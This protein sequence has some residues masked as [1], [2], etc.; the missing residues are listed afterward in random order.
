MIW[1]GKFDIDCYLELFFL[2]EY[3]YRP[4]PPLFNVFGNTLSKFPQSGEIFAI[5]LK[6]QGL[7]RAVRSDFIF[8]VCN[9]F[10]CVFVHY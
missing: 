3:F 10:F 7:F 6:D 1:C 9:P 4:S 5:D 8:R 2:M